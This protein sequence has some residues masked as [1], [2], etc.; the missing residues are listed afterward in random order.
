MTE[1]TKI[2]CLVLA[3]GQSRRMG[4]GDKFLKR[5]G[6]RSILDH[7]LDTIEPQ[8][9][10]ILISSNS[11]LDE[12]RYPVV[13]DCLGGHL[14]PLAGILTG[15]EYFLEKGDAGTHMLSIP[16]DAPFIPDN[17]VTRL[18]AGLSSSSPAI[19]MAYS[20]GRIHP[21]V[22]LW[23]FSLAGALRKAI[24]KEDLRKILVFAERYSLS[25]VYWK[26]E[27]G[28]PFYNINKPEDFSEAEKLLGP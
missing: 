28:D 7:V 26:E 2:P 14:G 27:E 6:G 22:A 25:K 8:V 20:K 16:A 13:P 10:D 19:V 4:G 21:V 12:M 24:C 18:Q 9:G 3:G 5:L 1:F 11:D 17:L 15:L 23:P